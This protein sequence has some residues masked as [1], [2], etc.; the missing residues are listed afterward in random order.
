MRLTT[1]R[2]ADA[3]QRNLEMLIGIVNDPDATTEER[4][5]AA[6]KLAK[7]G[8]TIWFDRETGEPSF[9]LAEAFSQATSTLIDPN[10]SEAEK[11]AAAAGLQQ[12]IFTNGER[13]EET[14][15]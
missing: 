2:A 3:G 4:A 14:G 15:A 5:E 9:E 8:E 11:R 1:Q 12:F 7:E 13:R 6:T 10:A